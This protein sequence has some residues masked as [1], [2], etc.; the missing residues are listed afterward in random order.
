MLLRDDTAPAGATPAE[1]TSAEATLRHA[2][3]DVPGVAAELT[4]E[5]LRR[6]D[7]PVLVLDGSH[8]IAYANDRAKATLPGA[9]DGSFASLWSDDPAAVASILGEVAAAQ[10]WMTFHLT[11]SGGA[12]GV[13]EV[14]LRGRPMIVNRPPVE[15]LRHL[16]ITVDP[17]SRPTTGDPSPGA[18]GPAPA[19]H[20]ASEA[21]VGTRELI[22]RVKNNLSLLVSLVRAARRRVSDAEADEEMSGFERRLM[23]IAAIHD[24]LDANRQTD[25]V[26][27]DQL[28]DRVCTGLAEALAPTAVEV[29]CDLEAVTLPVA[30]ATPLGLVVNEIVTNALKHGFPDERSGAVTVT[31]R[32]LDD[33]SCEVR[34]ADD[35]VGAAVASRND[36]A[37]PMSCGSGNR[38]VRSLVEQLGG[39]LV[40]EPSDTG[41]AFAIAFPS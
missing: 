37:A 28:L 1:Y 7:T 6:I 12:R 17:S 26:R 32:S 18:V 22:H 33:G 13:D 20:A 16:L 35:G 19:P 27:A 3:H 38:I 9:A 2:R 14:A 10:D 34:I 4:M 31:L 5:A 24:V 40:A 41:A 25:V 11:R 15:P 23:S 21:D 30:L 39:T 36:G 8:R 29:V